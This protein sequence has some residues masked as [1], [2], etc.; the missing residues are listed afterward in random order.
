MFDGLASVNPEGQ[1]G[2]DN[3]AH[4][5]MR[6]LVEYRDYL[7]TLAR[8]Q[9]GMQWQGKL[10][11]S[12]I[13]QQTILRAHAGIDQFRGQTEA[14]WLGW[15]R[16]ILAHV[17]CSVA[18]EFETA[19]RD[20]TRELSLEAELEQSSTRLER[21]LA[22]DQS[23]PSHAAMRTE[24]LIRLTQALV[25]LPEDER[26]AVELHH[27]KGMT[28]AD[29]ASEIGRTRPAAVGLLFRAM[30]RLRRIMSSEEESGT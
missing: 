26:R 16:T 28:V 21:I 22:V 6:S 29:V 11:A 24:D 14:E 15:L 20:V 17:L 25:R 8:L 1:F 18:R 30:K 23:S 3:N 12:D 5:H 19:A 9:L 10:D 4:G 13:V 2:M 7:L 27:L